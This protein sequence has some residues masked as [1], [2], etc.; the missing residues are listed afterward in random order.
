[1]KW[2]MVLLPPRGDIWRCQEPGLVVTTQGQGSCNPPQGTGQPPPATHK[3]LSGPK[4][5]NLLEVPPF[6]Y[7]RMDHNL[8]ILQMRKLRLGEAR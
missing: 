6:S 8:P 1:M 5:G 3:E 2:E 7:R 4:L